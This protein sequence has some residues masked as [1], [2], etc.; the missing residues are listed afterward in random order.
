MEQKQAQHKQWVGEVASTMHR[1]LVKQHGHIASS[2]VTSF[3]LHSTQLHFPDTLE[4]STFSGHNRN[5][6]FTPFCLNS[7]PKPISVPNIFLID[8]L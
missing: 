4:M 8:P 1:N 3:S 6:L 2:F 7:P 5:E